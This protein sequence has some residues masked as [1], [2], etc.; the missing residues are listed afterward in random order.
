MCGLWAA[1]STSSAPCDTRYF[2]S[3]L[4]PCT[5]GLT[6]G[7]SPNIVNESLYKIVL[8][9]SYCTVRDCKAL[10]WTDGGPVSSADLDYLLCIFCGSDVAVWFVVPEILTPHPCVQFQASSWKS[11]ILKVCR[12]AYPPLPNHLPYELQYL[13]KQIFKTNPKDRP[14]LHTILTSHR[15][16]RLLRTHLPPQVKTQSPP[17]HF[18]VQCHAVELPAWWQSLKAVEP[19]GM[20]WLPVHHND[21]LSR[22]GVEVRI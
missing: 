15:V 9:S 8:L 22:H 5:T 10:L 13:I 21:I 1:F 14:S 2:P 18:K 7:L 17:V 11:L 19:D 12:G 6:V 20:L 3:L 4:S 16:S